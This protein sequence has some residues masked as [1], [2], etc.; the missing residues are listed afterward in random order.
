MSYPKLH[1][2]KELKECPECGLDMGGRS[3]PKHALKHWPATI[4]GRADDP[5]TQ[6]ARQRKALLDSAQPAKGG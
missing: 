4:P 5:T 1:N 2:G 6:Q 3:G